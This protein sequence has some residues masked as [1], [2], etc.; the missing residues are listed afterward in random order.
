MDKEN[1]E[2]EKM[3]MEV[4]G[5]IWSE[6]SVMKLI[7]D[8]KCLE[9]RDDFNEAP[10]HWAVIKGRLDIVKKLLDSGADPNFPTGLHFKLTPLQLSAETEYVAIS[11]L[12]IERGA[13]INTQSWRNQ[14]PIHFAIE[15]DK[16][17]QLKLLVSHGAD[18]TLK[19]ANDCYPLDQALKG[20]AFKCAEFLLSINAKKEKSLEDYLKNAVYWKDVDKITWLLD[21]GADIALIGIDSLIENAEYD[22]DEWDM[23]DEYEQDKAKTIE[24]LKKFKVEQI[25]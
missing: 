8:K 14:A 20:K 4:D 10:I 16:L 11:N 15:E 19:S 17:E 2:I 23:W 24:F 13:D 9:I 18:L 21:H 3:M 25:V 22:V 5:I 6:D 7:Q 1:E 12:L